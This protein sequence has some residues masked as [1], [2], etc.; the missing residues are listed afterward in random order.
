MY[1]EKMEKKPYILRRQTHKKIPQK[2]GK[3][4]KKR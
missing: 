2:K 1:T 3:M 4:T